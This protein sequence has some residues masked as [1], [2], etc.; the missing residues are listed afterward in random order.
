MQNNIQ[1]TWQVEYTWRNINTVVLCYALDK[2]DFIQLL[3]GCFT[4]TG[5]LICMI[6]PLA[7]KYSCVV[8]GT[9]HPILEAETT[10]LLGQFLGM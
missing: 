10:V 1:V 4:N 7:L 8:I 5:V 6:A 3:Q 9:K 2:V